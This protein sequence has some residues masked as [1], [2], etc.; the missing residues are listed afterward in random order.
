MTQVVQLDRL[1][2]YRVSYEYVQV[3]GELHT[4]S[5]SDGFFQGAP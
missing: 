4:S 2:M 3:W 1:Y 5:S